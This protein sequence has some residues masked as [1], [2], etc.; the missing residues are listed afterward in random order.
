M[1]GQV[2]YIG[3]IEFM[4]S[5][6]YILFVFIVDINYGLNGQNEWEREGERIVFILQSHISRR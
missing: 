1:A 2:I 6:G 5:D 3:N 4:F